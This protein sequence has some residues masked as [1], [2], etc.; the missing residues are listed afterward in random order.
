[1]RNA[2]MLKA[3]DRHRKPIII[4]DPNHQNHLNDRNDPNHLNDPNDPNHLND[5][6][7]P[8]HP[9]EQTRITAT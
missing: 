5:H 4:N 1:M 2:E 7:D 8:D 6:N 3:T 9:N